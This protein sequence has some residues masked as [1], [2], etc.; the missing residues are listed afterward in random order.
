MRPIYL[1]RMEKVRPVVVLTR[2]SARPL[3]TKITVAPIYSIVR[4]ITTEVLVGSA[5]GLDH[6]SAVNCDNITTIP[7][8]DLG[9]YVGSLTND[10]ESA[11]AEAIA[12]AL[13]LD[14]G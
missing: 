10:Q 4:G 11:L 2:Q 9:R 7:A 6:E 3:L 13:D 5:N 12:Y 8:E 1:A 14:F